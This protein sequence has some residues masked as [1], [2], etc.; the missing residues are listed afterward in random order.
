[1][2]GFNVGDVKAKDQLKA[3]FIEV[4]EKAELSEMTMKQ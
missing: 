4:K 1:V 2:G 3:Q